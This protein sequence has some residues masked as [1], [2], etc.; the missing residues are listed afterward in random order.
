[1]RLSCLCPAIW[2]RSNPGC[3]SLFQES[4]SGA[5]SSGP[6]SQ[7]GDTRDQAVLL[8]PFFPFSTAKVLSLKATVLLLLTLLIKARVHVRR[9]SG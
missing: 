1:M 4:L 7:H 3:G 9:Q 2:L 5:T 8:N 6:A